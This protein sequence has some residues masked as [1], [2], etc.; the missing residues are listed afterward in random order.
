MM[1]RLSEVVV[2]SGKAQGKFHKLISCH[3]KMLA[4]LTLSQAHR[5]DYALSTY[6]RILGIFGQENNYFVLV[7]VIEIL[8]LKEKH[9]K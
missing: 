5:E 8:A 7:G 3:A 4:N 2:K 1:L 6:R 9:N